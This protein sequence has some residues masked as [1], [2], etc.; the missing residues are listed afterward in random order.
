M[1]EHKKENN[2][3]QFFKFLTTDD[4]RFRKA[5][6]YSPFITAIFSF[7]LNWLVFDKSLSESLFAS[8]FIFLLIC[9]IG[10]VYEATKRR[11]LR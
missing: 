3:A 4:L 7:F 1:K 9:F 8:A 10:L 11:N 2:L 6:L 5:V